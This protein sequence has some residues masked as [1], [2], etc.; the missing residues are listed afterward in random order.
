MIYIEVS[1][2]DDE[3]GIIGLTHYQP[4]ILPQTMLDKGFL[5]ESIPAEDSTRYGKRCVKYYY[6]KTKEIKYEYLDNEDSN[7]E[8]IEKLQKDN[9]QLLKENVKKDAIIESLSKDVADIYKMV[10][11]NK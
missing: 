6:Y 5:V 1:R 9:A 3:K 4:E 7:K 10:G 11:G 8:I 2:I